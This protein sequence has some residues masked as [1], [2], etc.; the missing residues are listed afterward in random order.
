MWLIVLACLF[1]AV[2]AIWSYLLVSGRNPLPFPDRGSR[3]FSTPSPE[4]KDAIVALLAR[5]GVNERFQANSSGILRSIMWDG[6]IINQ[7]PPDVLRKLGHASAS[8][9]LVAENPEASAIDA[10]EFLRSRG[11]EAN[12]VLDAE[13]ALPI[14]FVVTNATSGTVLNFRKHLIHMPRPQRARKSRE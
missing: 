7:A 1:F 10:A 13:P 4:A 2:L 9:G 3:I 6:T 11:F 5:H 12:V 14:A 8:I